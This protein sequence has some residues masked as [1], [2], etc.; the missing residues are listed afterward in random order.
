MLSLA[1][2]GGRGGGMSAY[3]QGFEVRE[4]LLMSCATCTI[5]HA[6]FQLT[7]KLDAANQSR[8]DESHSRTVTLR[9]TPE[10]SSGTDGAKDPCPFPHVT[11]FI[12]IYA[13]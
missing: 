2:A 13:D 1:G 7:N 4:F 3:H 12:Y 6:K 5:A 10:T 9:I 11:T 8:A